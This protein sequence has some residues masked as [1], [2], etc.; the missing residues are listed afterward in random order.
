MTNISTEKELKQA[1]DQHILLRGAAGASAN[2][3]DREITPRL[4]SELRKVFERAGRID[5]YRI[6][7]KQAGKVGGVNRFVSLGKD[8]YVHQLAL[9]DDEWIVLARQDL[10]RGTAAIAAI[11][12]LGE[13][14]RE[15]HSGRDLLVDGMTVEQH[16][17]ALVA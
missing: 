6:L 10:S 14:Y 13:R 11:R 1:I 7:I 17:R 5:H 4:S 15:L 16:V 9:G 2:D 3:L 8:R 12:R